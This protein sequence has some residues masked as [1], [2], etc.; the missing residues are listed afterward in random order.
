MYAAACGCEQMV[1]ILLD[2]GADMKAQTWSLRL[3][4]Y[5]PVGI[6]IE[7]AE[8]D[9]PKLSSGLTALDIAKRVGHSAVVQ[10]LEKAAAKLETDLR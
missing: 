4:R 2:A 10:V 1:H 9:E 6:P 7:A 3:I 8:A 5:N